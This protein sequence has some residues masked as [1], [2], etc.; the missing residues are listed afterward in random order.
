M[1]AWESWKIASN[2]LWWQSQGNL[3]EIRNNMTS[4]CFDVL[5][6]AAEIVENNLQSSK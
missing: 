5:I 2:F 6:R 3:G 4:T 1:E